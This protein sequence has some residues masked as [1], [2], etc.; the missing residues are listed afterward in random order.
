MIRRVVFDT[1][2]LVGAALRP[3]SVPGHAL[4]EAF[5]SCLLCASEEALAELETVLGRRKFD[6]YLDRASR[7]EFVVLVRRHSHLFATSALPL[8]PGPCRDPKD[9]KFL[10][11]ALAAKADCLV[12]SDQDLRVLH[13]WRNITILSPAEFLNGKG[14]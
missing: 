7:Q 4:S 11:L 14:G 13:P 5:A 1:S 10:A 12:S 3:D 6:R 2:T 8:D 9:L